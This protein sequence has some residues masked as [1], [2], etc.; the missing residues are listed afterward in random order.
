MTH[1]VS[2]DIRLLLLRGQMPAYWGFDSPVQP[3]V[4][5]SPQWPK[6]TA[7]LVDQFQKR[8]AIRSK[9]MCFDITKRVVH[10]MTAGKVECD[11]VFKLVFV[12]VE[13]FAAE[14]Q[15]KVSALVLQFTVRNFLL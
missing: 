2:D 12:P 15:N 4:V 9:E 14:R 7:E 3:S 5:H 1:C 8:K 6:H 11:E 10:T 13:L